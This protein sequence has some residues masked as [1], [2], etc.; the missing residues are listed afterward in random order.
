VLLCTHTQRAALL[1]RSHARAHLCQELTVDEERVARQRA[2]AERQH[3]E[4][5]DQVAQPLVV[6][7]P[8]GA[9]AHQ[10]VAPAHCLRGLQV[11]ETR[12]E[13]A[14]LGLRAVARDGNEL[15]QAG[16]CLRELVEQ[17]EAVVG[18]DLVV[19][20]PET[21]FTSGWRAASRLQ[22]GT[23][24]RMT[25][26]GVLRCGGLRC[27]RCYCPLSMQAACQYAPAG[28][29]TAVVMLPSAQ[30]I[31]IARTGRCAACRRRSPRSPSAAARSRC[32]CPHR[33]P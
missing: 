29:S 17:P 32:G 27:M 1:R 19:A 23:W 4:P 8:R 28:W 12:H 20:R 11:R 31:V 7:L 30:R 10:P 22:P 33:R 26:T 6:A 15:L 13:H 3:G 24:L 25:V 21:G 9:V 16:P 5:R 18:G 2:R 14:R